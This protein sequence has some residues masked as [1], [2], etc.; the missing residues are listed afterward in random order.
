MMDRKLLAGTLRNLA[1]LI[2]TS[3]DDEYNVLMELGL[4]AIIK[5]SADSKPRPKPVGNKRNSDWLIERVA[6]SLQF[7]SS[8]E[9]GFEILQR[10]ELNR[11]D[12][13][14]LAKRLDLPVLREDSV[15]RLMEK[16]VESC[17]GVRLNS[18]AIRGEGFRSAS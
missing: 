5:R 12:L 11:A 8:R 6:E 10:S 18:E 17:I 7:V 3:D 13:Q 4:G 1:T 9:S 14:S 16:I 2:E 15:H